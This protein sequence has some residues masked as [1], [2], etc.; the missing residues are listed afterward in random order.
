[1]II[2]NHEFIQGSVLNWTHNLEP[3]RFSIAVGVSYHSDVRQVEKVLVQCAETC[4]DII[5]TAGYRPFVRFADD[6]LLFA[7]EQSKAEKAL[8]FAGKK[9]AQMDLELHPSKTRVVRSSRKII[10]LGEPLPEPSKARR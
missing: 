5:T 1:M 9:L 8:A 4:S 2:P 3:T 7:D 6:F 10:F